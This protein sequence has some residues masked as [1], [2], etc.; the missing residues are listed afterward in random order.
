MKSTRNSCDQPMFR[1][2]LISSAIH[3]IIG[4]GLFLTVYRF[5]SVIQPTRLDV[6]VGSQPVLTPALKKETSA[7]FQKSVPD[8]NLVG[9]DARPQNTAE[10]TVENKTD[11]HGDLTSAYLSQLLQT[12]SKQKFYPKASIL[13]QESG[14]VETSLTLN[15]SGV[16]LGAEVVKSSGFLNLDAAALKT[17]R[18]ISV[19]SPPPPE[20]GNP[21][22]IMVPIRYEL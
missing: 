10:K 7:T 17:L 14:V 3:F 18:S 22:T 13:N 9:R 19:F 15:S 16:L 6:Q 4:I 2:L 12:I 20:L 5:F 1:S 8:L 21:V 11:L